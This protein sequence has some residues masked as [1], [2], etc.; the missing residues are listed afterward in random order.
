MMRRPELPPGVADVFHS[1]NNVIGSSDA[2]GE[3]GQVLASMRGVVEKYMEDKRMRDLNKRL[4]DWEQ[5]LA[6]KE[7]VFRFEK[8]KRETH[9]HSR[10]TIIMALVIRTMSRCFNIG[11]LRLFFWQKL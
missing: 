8:E 6:D 9:T 5:S 11:L 1:L 3:E 4:S 10:L 7:R 2:G